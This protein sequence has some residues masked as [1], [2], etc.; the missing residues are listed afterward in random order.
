MLLFLSSAFAFRAN[1]RLHPVSD[2]VSTHSTP[3]QTLFSPKLSISPTLSPST[4]PTSN[5]VIN[6]PQINIIY[7]CFVCFFGC[8]MVYFVWFSSAAAPQNGAR[9]EDGHRSFYSPCFMLGAIFGVFLQV[10]RYISTRCEGY[11]AL[12]DNN[13]AATSSADLWQQRPILIC[14]YCIYLF[15]LQSH[16]PPPCMSMSMSSFS[17][18]LQNLDGWLLLLAVETISDLLADTARSLGA[19]YALTTHI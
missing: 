17:A 9:T 6:I 11:H 10:C 18:W 14:V 13:N 15:I 8:L 4:K 16:A 5:P 7:I 19:S 1:G 3:H 2:P 12:D